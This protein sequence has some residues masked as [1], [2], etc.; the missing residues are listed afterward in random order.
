M[1]YVHLNTI[2]SVHEHNTERKNSKKTKKKIYLCCQNR[3][4]IYKFVM[5]M[6][7]SLLLLNL[8]IFC[9][10]LL[11]SLP[12]IPTFLGSL[13]TVLLDFGRIIQDKRQEG[14]KKKKKTWNSLACFSFTLLDLSQFRP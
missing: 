2:L 13:R 1:G 8:T 6:I 3:Q 4:N 10:D 11:F 9:C 12:T 7:R 14:D 5:N